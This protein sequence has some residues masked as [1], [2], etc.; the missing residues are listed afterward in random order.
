[1]CRTI[2]RILLFCLSQRISRL[3]PLDRARKELHFGVFW[4]ETNFFYDDADDDVSNMGSSLPGSRVDIFV[5]LYLTVFRVQTDLEKIFCGRLIICI[6]S[7]SRAAIYVAHWH[8]LL[9]RGH[10]VN[11]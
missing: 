5:G 9:A 6:F 4:C 10:V 3:V 7:G 8:A 11:F 2:V 1:M